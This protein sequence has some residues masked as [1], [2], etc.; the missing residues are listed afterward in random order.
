MRLNHAFDL[1]TEPSAMST[2][3]ELPANVQA[4]IRPGIITAAANWNVVLPEGW[5][6]TFDM[7]INRFGNRPLTGAVGNYLGLLRQHWRFCAWT[8]DYDSMLMLV[9]PNAARVPAMKPQSIDLLLRFK[10]EEAGTPL[11]SVANFP[12]L[13]FNGQQVHCDGGWKNPQKA[14]HFC[15]AISAL[16]NAWDDHANH[17]GYV[18]ACPDCR[19]IPIANRHR[20]CQVCATTVGPRLYRIGN[21]CKSQLVKNTLK[22][23]QDPN[24]QEMGNSQLTPKELRLIRAALLATNTLEGLATYT[25]ILC[26]CKLFA[27]QDEV[28][29]MQIEHFVPELFLRKDNRVYAL[30]V[31]IRGKTDGGQWQYRWIWAD[32]ECPDLCPVRHLLCY[33]FL[34]GHMG[35]FLFPRSREFG[36]DKPAD[37][38]YTTSVSYNTFRKWFKDFIAT[39]LRNPKLKV[40]LHMW[41]KT[42][43]LLGIWGNGDWADLKQSARH[44][45]DTEA[46]KYAK[47][48]K[49]LM[50]LHEIFRDP[51][52]RVGKWR[53]IV[54]EAPSQ[55]ARMAATGSDAQGMPLHQLAEEFVTNSLGC[56]PGHAHRSNQY[57]LLQLS[58]N[59]TCQPNLEEEI[60]TITQNYHVDP[61]AV[62]AMQSVYDR[63]FLEERQR[64]IAN[65]QRQNTQSAA[66]AAPA[67]SVAQFTVAVSNKRKRGGDNDLQGRHKIAKLQ[68]VREKVE[69]IRQLGEQLPENT[70]DL[71]EAARTYN[72]RAIKPIL[73]CLKNHCN[74]DLD[75][76]VARWGNNFN[77]KFDSRCCKGEEGA[78]C[79]G[80]SH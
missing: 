30:C 45:T 72:R 8:K 32:D 5:S 35:G 19:S 14:N 58:L 48:A 46:E 27:R 76:F 68:T 31:K 18:E 52:N 33:I 7:N 65:W 71:T 62:R 21:P 26:G 67:V 61:L 2:V 34:S 69:A 66:A 78:V 51:M 22:A 56:P 20:G 43:Y 6:D 29:S 10:R 70:S 40:G 36:R 79:S 75:E 38:I 24:Y 55:A 63:Y 16:H 17:D 23:V 12:V 57:E 3:S 73:G 44:K 54:C 11:E 64:L 41:R 49:S 42:A 37:G 74:N 13:D 25:M 47:D 1:I 39:L 4:G 28:G 9:T 77:F 59:Y 80:S 60:A 50:Q 15:S 53:S